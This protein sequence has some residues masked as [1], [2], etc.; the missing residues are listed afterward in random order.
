G[1]NSAVRARYAEHF[2]PTV[3]PTRNRYT[4]LGTRRPFPA[5]TFFFRET[6]FGWFQAHCYQFSEDTST[7]IVECTDETWRAAGLDRMT[8]P[9]ALAFCEELYSHHMGGHALVDNAPHLEGPAMWLRFPMVNSATWHHGHVVLLGDAA[10]T[11]HFST[12]S[13]TKLALE[14]A[15]ALADR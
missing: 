8:K 14:S 10:A 4:W 15:I 2:R 13:G 11:A 7:F 6:A 5:F 1:V 12:G 3:E 9:Q